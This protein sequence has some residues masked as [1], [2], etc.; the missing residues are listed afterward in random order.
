M[1]K[2]KTFQG[3]R[4]GSEVRSTGCLAE[5]LGLVPRTHT[6]ALWMGNIP[7]PGHPG[8][9]VMS[10]HRSQSGERHAGLFLTIFLLLSQPMGPYPPSSLQFIP[11]SGPAAL[12]PDICSVGQAK[13]HF[14]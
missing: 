13:P 14:P 10:H 5:G 9:V 7:N 11:C 3:W 1:I 6:L 2:S 12:G 8:G 4:D